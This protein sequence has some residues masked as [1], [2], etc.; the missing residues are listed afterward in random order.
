MLVRERGPGLVYTDARIKA[1]SYGGPRQRQAR[2]RADG[3]GKRGAGV[4][5]GIEIGRWV[6]LQV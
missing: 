4:C 1:R 2:G 5:V 3:A 6:G